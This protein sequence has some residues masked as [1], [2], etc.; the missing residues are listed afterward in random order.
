M[1]RKQ[2]IGC[3]FVGIMAVTAMPAEIV[4]RIAPPRDQRENRGRAPARGHVW[5]QG[6]QRYDNNAYSWV[7]GR[8]E[9]PPRPRARWERPRW[10]RRQGSYVFIEGRWR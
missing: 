9:A 2:L 1:F 5:V 6:Y 10:Q 4:V 3:L 7:P 8:W